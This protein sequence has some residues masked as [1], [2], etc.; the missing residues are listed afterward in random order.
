MITLEVAGT[1][2]SEFTSANVQMRMD[3]LSNTFS[4]SA[5]TSQ[6]DPLPFKGGDSVRVFVDE[7][8]VLTGSIEMVSASYDSGNHVVTFDGRDK[9]GDLL[10]S[11]IGSLSDIKAPITLATLCRRVIAHIGSDIEVIDLANP[12]IFSAADDIS[13]PEPGEN[14]FGFLQKYS[15]KRQV[16]LSSNADGNLLI[17]SSSGETID[18]SINHRIGNSGGINNVVRA[19]VSYDS[20]GRFNLYR[21]ISQLNT[22]A[23]SLAGKLS[24]KSVSDQGSKQQAIDADI[25]TGRQMILISEAATSGK[26]TLDRATWEAN[27]R[28]ARGRVYSPE[29]SG[30][31]DQNGDLWRINTLPQVNDE[32]ADIEARMLVNTVSFSNSGEDGSEKTVI[33]F[34]EKDAFTLEISEPI[35]SE[36]KTGG[37]LFG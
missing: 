19:D 12:K 18:A 34:V 17:T 11:S 20:T 14:L 5:A 9:T 4:F 1:Q 36:E 8:L 25:R 3:A 30:F 28:K 32:F 16:L 10:D 24:S 15:L 31:R 35:E 37:G 6:N 33:A 22:S 13:S 26:G 27:M 7:E 29:L 21:S 2:Y 23:G